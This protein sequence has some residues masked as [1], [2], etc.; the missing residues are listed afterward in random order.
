MRREANQGRNYSVQFLACREIEESDQSFQIAE[1]S[2]C[3]KNAVYQ[4]HV[5]NFFFFS[6]LIIQQGLQDLSSLTGDGT[7]APC[8]GSVES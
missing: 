8:S 1:E 5:P 4:I 2:L 6:F 3:Y 7:R